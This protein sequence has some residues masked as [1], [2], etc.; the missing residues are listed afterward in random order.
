MKDEV[1]L[2]AAVTLLGVL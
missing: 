2:L 1:A